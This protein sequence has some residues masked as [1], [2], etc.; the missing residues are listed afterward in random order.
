MAAKCPW[1]GGQSLIEEVATLSQKID[2]ERTNES[3]SQI[4]QKFKEGIIKQIRNKVTIDINELPEVAPEVL[5]YLADILDDDTNLVSLE[6]LISWFQID[7]KVASQLEQLKQTD[8][9]IGKPTEEEQIKQEFAGQY[10]Q[11]AFG[12]VA[13]AKQLFNNF[14][15]HISVNSFIYID[16][17]QT[18]ICKNSQD[19]D[20]AI[21]N[22]Q[23]ELFQTVINYI[24]SVYSQGGF[25][26]DSAINKIVSRNNEE[27]Y[28]EVV[29]LLRGVDKSG[30]KYYVKLTPTNFNR[31][32]KY[33]S[34][35]FEQPVNLEGL[36]QTIL[37]PKVGQ[38]DDKYKAQK[39]IDA[40]NSWVLLNNFD[41]VI[42][43]TFGDVVAIN[44]NI[45][46]FKKG[47]F[48]LT[49]KGTKLYSTWRNTD[50][51]ILDKEINNVTQFI[52]TSLPMYNYNGDRIEN[53]Y[54]QFGEFNHVITAKLKN[55][56]YSPESSLDIKAFQS[57]KE[58]LS[59]RI[60]D[61]KAMEIFKHIRNI[62]TIKELV[63]LLRLNPEAYTKDI[64]YI[65]GDQELFTALGLPQNQ[66]TATDLDIIQTI[67]KNL[68]TGEHSLSAAIDR[69]G[70]NTLNY[71]AYVTQSIDSMFS[72]DF[73]QYYEN[74]RTNTIKTQSLQDSTIQ[75]KQR[76]LYRTISAHNTYS[77]INYSELEK[78]FNI[79][80]DVN[81]DGNLYEIRYE[82]PINKD[83]K[84]TVVFNPI[85]QNNLIFKYKDVSYTTVA[86][87]DMIAK[88]GDDERHI[89]AQFVHFITTKNLE[90]E[91]FREAYQAVKGNY[92]F[93]EPQAYSDLLILASRV[94]DNIA[95]SNKL[96]VTDEGQRILNKSKL[97]EKIN[98]VYANAQDFKPTINKVLKEIDLVS[99]TN[100][101]TLKD[102]ATIEAYMDHLLT[103]S[104][105]KD[106]AGNGAS[107]Q[108]LSRLLG[109]YPFQ[110]KQQNLKDTSASKHFSLFD[111]NI[112]LG[113][114]Q[115]KEVKTARGYKPHTDFTPQEFETACLVYDYFM[116]LR[117]PNNRNT[118]NHQVLRF[119][120]AIMSDKPYIGRLKVD[121]DAPTK[122]QYVTEYPLDTLSQETQLQIDNI[123]LQKISD[124]TGADIDRI[125][126][127]YAN[128][129]IGVSNKLAFEN[130]LKDLGYTNEAN[131]NII[132]G[133]ILNQLGIKLNLTNRLVISEYGNGDS[134][135]ELIDKGQD[136]SIKQIIFKEL[137]EF[138]ERAK[139]QIDNDWR[140]VNLALNNYFEEVTGYSLKDAKEYIITNGIATEN[141]NVL[142]TTDFNSFNKQVVALNKAGYINLDPAD[143]V[144]EITR[145]HN[146]NNPF[147]VIKLTD[148]V[149]YEV[150]K[151]N[152][153]AYSEND[154]TPKVLSYN[155]TLEY[156][157]KVFSTPD[158]LQ[159]YLKAGEKEFL[160]D[161]LK[162]GFE[163][164][165]L[166][167][168]DVTKQIKALNT[169][170]ISDVSGKLILGRFTQDGITYNLSSNIEAGKVATMIMEKLTGKPYTYTNFTQFL[171]ELD[172]RNIEYNI[173]LNDQ[174]KV[175][176]SLSYL[177]SQEFIS[178]LVGS[179]YAHPGKFT[180]KDYNVP[181]E[182]ELSWEENA[183]YAA[184]SKRNVS[185]TA[186]MQ[187]YQLNQLNG[188][189][190]Q[191]NIAVL[192]D[193]KDTVYNVHGDAGGSSGT[194][195]P[196]D[197]AT[198]VNP[199]LVYLENNSL[200]GA[201]AGVIKKPYV[202][203]YDETTGTGGMIKTAGFGMTNAVMRNSK[204]YSM[205]TQNMTDRPWY[206][207]K[208]QLT[209]YN[210][211]K[212]FNTLNPNEKIDLEF[213]NS[214][215]QNQD[216]SNALFAYKDED[217]NIYRVVAIKYNGKNSY[218][219][220]RELVSNTNSVIS[221]DTKTFDNVNT[222]YKLWQMFGGKGSVEWDGN[223][224]V[225]SEYS[226]EAVVDAINK[227]GFVQPNVTQIRYQDDV[228]QPLKHSDIHY[229]PTAGAVK[230]GAGN[231][232]SIKYIHEP[233]KLNF[234]TI[235]M[236]QAGIQL[237]KEHEAD[238]EEISLM[239]QVVSA[240]VSRGYSLTK[241]SKMYQAL[242]SL[243][244]YAI[245]DS[246]EAYE[247]ILSNTSE[248]L[249][250]KEEF[251]KI[252]IDTIVDSIIHQDSKNSL[253]DSIKT[254][255]INLEKANIKLNTKD[256]AKLIPF[257]D[258]ALFNSLASQLS[259][260]I[261]KSAIKLKIDGVL[262]ILCP[263]YNLMKI[264]GGKKLGEWTTKEL[265]EA[266]KKE[267]L[268]TDPNQLRIG[269]CYN[270]TLKD[271]T[272]LENIT[273]KIPG[274]STYNKDGS[275]NTWG[276]M[277]IKQM[278]SS[279]EIQHLQNDILNGRELAHYNCIFN[280]S[281]G[282]TYQLYDLASVQQAHNIKHTMN[283][284]DENVKEL[285]KQTM[286]QVQKDLETITNGHGTIEI[287]NSLNFG[288]L[289]TTT[290]KVEVNGKPKVESAEV[291]LP[292]VF[293]T[294]YGLQ[295]NDELSYI[296]E[297]KEKFFEARLMRNLGSKID[298]D[299][300]DVELKFNNGQ[301]IYIA[302]K[303]RRP[304]HFDE[305][306]YKKNI[307]VKQ[308]ENG[309]VWRINPD[310]GEKMYRMANK[311]DEVYVTYTFQGTP[312]EVIVSS[313]PEFY[314]A[315]T[316]GY[317]NI[318]LSEF[319][320]GEEYLVNHSIYLKAIIDNNPK[321]GLNRYMD[322]E[323][324]IK[325]D[326]YE[327][328]NN[329][330]YRGINS[331][332]IQLVKHIQKQAK[333]IYASFQKSLDI[334]AA[335]IPAQSMQSFMSMKIVAFDSTNSNT[336]Y[337]AS[338]QLWLQG[339][340]IYIFQ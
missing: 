33:F 166:D 328:Y 27:D 284:D 312:Q 113:V 150:N 218:T 91:Q 306:F 331:S 163:V 3:D 154:Y 79:N 219:L 62:R 129:S 237:D 241:S 158:S 259:V 12:H 205:I 1:N 64:F 77:K 333:Q 174:F 59:T 151:Q 304:D 167:N 71:L 212:G 47:R 106:G 256:L 243:A 274:L 288:E 329:P 16:S 208:Q 100:D 260:D 51:I 29:K 211:L 228:Y 262:S 144:N 57:V 160:C 321:M 278:L 302:E 98:Q 41:R 264:Y 188:A 84:V 37:D 88:M 250:N 249:N 35:L 294:A 195:K 261:T 227:T 190:T 252:I 265:A 181:S 266:Q 189:P 283:M 95:I 146:W 178:S 204:E 36:V 231:V 183:R 120:S 143:L 309:E 131:Y 87:K 199:W 24:R 217:G 176:N 53:K 296:N 298:M 234:F 15:K 185:Y 67:N 232:N 107:V 308:L 327:N 191:Y 281:D 72:A 293:Q 202:H 23:N 313:N 147:D 142:D 159:T 115:M 135:S 203:F 103:A 6:E 340:K 117:S 118:N 164:D 239:T 339:S 56:M 247:K 140:R 112:F 171:L 332:D 114:E 169:N 330:L 46:P 127:L 175:Y 65:L 148:Q 207:N 210:I 110:I 39:R 301:H 10:L 111:Q 74:E 165:L 236:Y 14:A 285:Y 335:R 326:F 34:N 197:G 92:F 230:Q 94:L 153:K 194:V 289:G 99:A 22:R 319:R 317:S 86:V 108:T 311:N 209:D 324:N 104:Q 70:H 177:F 263:A 49:S 310:T 85:G 97:Q 4:I 193:I 75:K 269:G 270:I 156:L 213:K 58:L 66:F 297:K 277:S 31:V 200:G 238:S 54:L 48:E 196:H 76:Q 272:R 124:W 105:V 233:G 325:Q 336:S 255:L 116:G 125:A 102:L 229:M 273:I 134:L 109:S 119:V 180:F 214:R 290:E 80:I 89:I 96:M 276:Y 280:A 216:G 30:R 19:F 43:D 126:E 7:Q 128:N 258:G 2:N 282:N 338:T 303:S 300:F 314:I 291:I 271:G 253:I 17:D 295:D 101:Q 286:R 240:C 78:L 318:V 275:V 248:A 173:N 90:S 45:I 130:T 246:V 292:R 50:Q 52:I 186:T 244:E 161:L 245:K 145:L 316:K 179:H 226:I 81:T 322:S 201:R 307:Q 182:Q 13:K 155:K 20:T 139:A 38:A 68:Y 8:D 82:I 172:N 184:Q 132:V 337:V 28:D 287:M 242:A 323:G 63:T 187:E 21:A 26:P 55:F 152:N 121:L 268:I 69:D 170:W 137:G 334:V 73:A 305:Q 157:R 138:Y 220:A 206:Y 123:L 320:N 133:N 279:G 224:Y 223:E 251:K 9:L 162:D 315:N 225:N 215:E 18:R 5:D 235:N 61:P 32:I 11:D 267:P 44:P 254:K 221:K 192:D 149:H 40:Y 93:D 299:Y 198:Y 168:T 136:Y 141:G 25:V 60:D 83:T 122:Y 222:N 42:K 257:S